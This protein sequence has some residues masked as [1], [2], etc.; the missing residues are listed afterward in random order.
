VGDGNAAEDGAV[1]DGQDWRA[2]RWAETHRRIYDVALSLFQE[3]G[4]EQV[5]VGQIAAGA[6]V[7]VPTFY[8]HYP[9]KEHLI[10]QLPTAAEMHALLASQP[11]ELPVA[12][13]IRRAMPVWF[14]TWDDEYR[15]LQLARWRIIA[16]TP[17]LRTRAAEFERATAGMVADALP[18]PAGGSLG[19]ADRVV[20]SAYLSAFTMGLLAWADGNGERKLEELVDEAFD[21][22]RTH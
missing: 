10:M 1:S 19:P 9:S 13:R 14:G 8:S 18:A 22:L 3:H 11:A 15:A 5:S 21:A 17:V 20:V 2:R 12:D 16:S 7:S 4:F 6:E